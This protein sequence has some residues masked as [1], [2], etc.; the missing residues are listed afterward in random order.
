MPQLLLPLPLS[1]RLA[2]FAIAAFGS[3]LSAQAHEVWIEDTPEGKLV[4]RFAEFGEKFE[5]S[6]G[7]LDALS[8]P[9]AWTTPDPKD[10]K[11]TAVAGDAPPAEARAILEGQVKSFETQKKSD[12]FLLVGAA[13]D[14]VAQIETGFTVMGKPGNPEKPAR[15]P[16]FYARWHPVG[17]GAGQPGANLD[18]VPTGKP[19]EARVFFRG[20]PLA[21]VKLKFHPPGAAEQELVSDADG[22]VRF[23]ATKPGFYLLAGARHRETIAGFFGGKPFDVTS[24]NC[25]LAWRQP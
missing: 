4:V 17:A 13:P 19:G 9:F 3:V 14:K 16:N 24:H 7:P 1:R 12:H 5:Q 21:D 22:L 20:K 6:P 23:E 2:L 15:K 8:L 11:A 25:S 18:I 10:P